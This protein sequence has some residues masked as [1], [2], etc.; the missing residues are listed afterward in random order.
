MCT[1]KIP[2][3]PQIPGLSSFPA[4]KL[5]SILGPSHPPLLKARIR[6]WR[7]RSNSTGNP[8]PSTPGH[9]KTGT[10]ELRSH[11]ILDH[12]PHGVMK[13]LPFWGESPGTNHPLS[14]YIGQHTQAPTAHQFNQLDPGMRWVGHSRSSSDAKKACW[15]LESYRIVRIWCIWC[16]WWS[17]PKK[18]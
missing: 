3:I 5:Q 17:Y 14:T 2:Q 13:V 16:I 18:R 12:F 7:S 9:V 1:P 6:T 10:R 4:S 11:K 8:S 15:E